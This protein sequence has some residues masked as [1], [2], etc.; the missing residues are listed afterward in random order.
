MLDVILGEDGS[1]TRK[2]DGPENLAILRRLALNVLRAHPAPFSM[3]Q[4]IKS[5]AW[6][7]S[8]LLSLFSHMR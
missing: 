4:K 7:D 1:R 8:F 3:R 6:D 2:D 5:A